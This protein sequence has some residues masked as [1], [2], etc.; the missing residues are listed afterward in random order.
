MAGISPVPDGMSR[1]GHSVKRSFDVFLSGL[2][3]IAF[4]PFKKYWIKWLSSPNLR[5]LFCCFL[6]ICWGSMASQAQEFSTDTL[7]LQ[8]Y[9]RRGESMVDPDYRDNGANLERFRASLND[10][11]AIVRNII[12]RTTSSPEGPVKFN[13]QLSEAR[14]RGIDDFLAGILHL[15]RS[16][17]RYELIGE[18]WD[19]LERAVRNLDTPWRDEVLSIIRNTPDYVYRDGKI[20]DGR[21]RQLMRLRNGKVWAWMDEHIFPDLR[22]AGGSVQCI[23]YRPV[24]SSTARKDTV[25][26][27]ESSVDTVFVGTVAQVTPEDYEEYARSRRDYNLDGKKMLFAL[28]T[29]ALAVPLAN[30]GAEVPLGERW[31]VEADWYYPWLWRPHHGEGLDYAGACFELLAGDLEARYWFPSKNKKPQQHLLG[32]SVG[33][34]AAAGYYD[35]ERGWSGHQGWFY[36]VGADYLYALPLFYG[37]MHL[38][39]ELGI[40]YIYSPAQPYDTFVAG[41]KAYRRK[42]VTQYTRWFGPTRAQ[43]SLVVPIYVT[44]KEEH[45]GK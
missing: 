37:R 25:Y 12:V 5:G 10:T 23:I 34:Y 7:S 29:N 4:A 43:I 16:L 13:Q 27:V 41:E 8:V 30:I 44:R 3:V 33:L 39:F 19:G 36:N 38:E 32:H 15:D 40:G 18:D 35:F 21:K 22:T 6:F 14:A 11:S 45:H 2:P 26:V 24:P 9:F 17:F 31:S 1:A 42:G 20:V 28:R